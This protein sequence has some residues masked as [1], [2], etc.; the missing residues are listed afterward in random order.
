MVTCG[1]T[2]GLYPYC[3]V[4]QYTSFR[5]IQFLIL[6]CGEVIMMFDIVVN[7]LLAYKDENDT[8][9]ITDTQIIAKK[10]VYHGNFIKDFVIW[11]PFSLL[12]IYYPVLKY[13]QIIKT[14]RFQ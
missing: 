3:M 13:I 9:Y 11:I 4:N 8:F 10:Y 6:M 1:I 14:V 12:T 7:L 5:D 2:A